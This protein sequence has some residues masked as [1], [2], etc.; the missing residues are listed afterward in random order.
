MTGLSQP[1][2]VKYF[3]NNFHHLGTNGTPYLSILPDNTLIVSSIYNS[4]GT[5]LVKLTRLGDTIWSKAY[6]NSIHS[7]ITAL[8]K[9]L[10][11]VN[12]NL[13]SVLTG[14]Y[15]AEL[16]T[17]GNIL[18]T[19]HIEGLDNYGF[20]DAAIFANGDKLIL[21]YLR[22]GY[23]YG[24]VLVRLDKSL[25]SIKWSKLIG[26]VGLNFSN[27]LIDGNTVVIAGGSFVS[28]YDFTAT[29]S[30]V[31]KIDGENGNIITTNSYRDPESGSGAILLYKSGSGYI[32]DGETHN[33]G[34]SNIILPYY[35]RL[36]S[37][38]HIQ[39]SKRMNEQPGVNSGIYYLLP[40]NDGSFY[41]TYGQNFNLTIFKVDG[42]DSVIWVKRQPNNMSFPGYLQQNEDG[43]FI[44]GLQNWHNVV[45][46]GAETNFF[47]CKSDFNGN[48]IGCPSLEQD[49][50]KTVDLPFT[51]A[52]F[53]L[54]S[55]DFPVTLSTENTIVSSYP[56]DFSF[57]CASVSPCNALTVIGDTAICDNGKVQFTGRKNQSCT[58][59]VQ[60]TLFPEQGFSLE[61]TSDSTISV[62]FTQSGDY[63]LKGSLTSCIETKDSMKLHVN[64]VPGIN[65]GPDTIICNNAIM[66]HAGSQFKTYL[67]QDG[68]TDSTFK[69]SDSGTFSVRVIDYCK[70]NYAD[71]IHIDR[72]HF[73]LDLPYDTV[74]CK[75]DTLQIQAAAGFSN[76]QWSPLSGIS[77]GS[78]GELATI[79]TKTDTSYFLTAQKWPGCTVLDTIHVKVK[80]QPQVDLGSD[81]ILC[82]GTV[83]LLQANNA[84]AIYSW[85]D[86]SDNSDFQVDRPGIYSVTVDLNG[87]RA[88][89]SIT[90]Q[91]QYP[92][93]ISMDK[94]AVLCRGQRLT[95]TPEISNSSDF[96]WQDGS[97]TPAYSIKDTGL[98]ILSAQNICGVTRD[99]IRVEGGLCEIFMPSAFTPNHDGVNDVFRVRYPFLVASFSLNVFNRWGQRIFET[100]DISKGWDGTVN[101]QDAQ[102]GGYVWF[103]SV[104]Y[105]N[106][107][108]E[109]LNGTVILIR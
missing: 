108:S 2:P 91:Y 8:T 109:N 39:V 18:T 62:Q 56:L 16:D 90:I 66:L 74:K 57:P 32:I 97:S 102:S 30:F 107:R 86:G 9:T 84:G 80:P 98:Y 64:L 72:A 35:I 25:N 100:K 6:N 42:K 95:L 43:L 34:G 41:G 44:T 75:N 13:F 26:G 47:L 76:Y 40:E 10:Y 29:V 45:T 58:N 48:L 4:S 15:L 33:S 50:I 38:L 28:P 106:G 14:K 27:V 11:D 31:S 85:Q 59:I 24:S 36:G 55:T 12:G 103:L 49:E 70:N 105:E 77:V 51:E 52:A 19:K 60:W 46:N 82:A 73:S 17:S 20:R 101:G 68:S 21:Y 89:D 1:C 7:D 71:T 3:Q 94:E 69:T 54:S 22:N 104:K 81:T 79:T 63:L 65:L 37:D 78:G 67:W 23:N 87:C 96:K 99:S 88:I 93:V 92:P 5:N 61:A 83:K 53:R